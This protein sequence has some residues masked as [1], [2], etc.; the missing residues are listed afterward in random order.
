M[1][2][3]VSPFYVTYPFLG[4][5]VICP[6][7]FSASPTNYLATD[8][9][10]V[11]MGPIYILRSPN[12]DAKSP[13]WDTFLSEMAFKSWMYQRHNSVIPDHF[14]NPFS[15]GVH[16]IRPFSAIFNYNPSLRPFSLSYQLIIRTIYDVYLRPSPWTSV[17]PGHPPFSWGIF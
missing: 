14:A 5:P 6:K 9:C 3:L 11:H 2:G 10:P 13:R 12:V 7:Y 1:P 8:H 4:D 17:L 16:L 15:P